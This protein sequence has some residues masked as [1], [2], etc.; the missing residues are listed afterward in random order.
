MCNLIQF[1]HV[2]NNLQFIILQLQLNDHTSTMRVLLREEIGKIAPG[3]ETR[4]VPQRVDNFL[5]RYSYGGKY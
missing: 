4:V 2:S 5:G 1:K 3:G